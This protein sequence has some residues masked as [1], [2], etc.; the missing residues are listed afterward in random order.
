MK[1]L[2][3]TDCCLDITMMRDVFYVDTEMLRQ[4][5]KINLNVGKVYVTIIPKYK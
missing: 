2:V 3:S 4:I 1:F 5:L